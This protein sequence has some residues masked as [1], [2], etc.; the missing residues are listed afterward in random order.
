MKHVYNHINPLPHSTYSTDFYQSTTLHWLKS[1]PHLTNTQKP[2]RTM[3]TNPRP[4]FD[5]TID[6]RPAGR[7]VFELFPNEVP[8]TADNFL[9]LCLGDKGETDAGV[10]LTYEGSGFH[11]VIKGFMLQ[12]SPRFGGRRVRRNE[13]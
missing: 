9:H 12:V 13:R 8:K 7:I 6:S 3:S 5:I 2:P 11:R 1:P 4:F 10:K